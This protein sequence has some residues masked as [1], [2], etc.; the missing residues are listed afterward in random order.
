MAPHPRRLLLVDD[1]VRSLR[2]LGQLLSED[3]YEVSLASN[4]NEALEKLAKAPSLDGLITDLRMPGA[5]GGT[6]A[7]EA[8]RLHPKVPVLFVTQ[9]TELLGQLE[10]E[11][12]PPLHI[13]G[14]PVSY[15][16]LLQALGS[17][18][19]GD[20]AMDK[21]Q[22]IVVGDDQS[23]LGTRALDTALDMAHSHGNTNVHVL[24]AVELVVDPL[25]PYA[26]IPPISAKD[27]LGK[28]QERVMVRV[29]AA[30][31]RHQQLRVRSVIAHTAVGD[32]AHALVDL[33]AELDADQI[34]VGTHGRTGF[35]RA[36]LG[37][38][39]ERVVRHSGCPVTVVRAKAHDPEKR[40]PDIEP[41]CP[42]CK[43]EREK[44]GD[45]N[46]WC[47]RHRE[48]H[49]RAHVYHEGSDPPAS[50]RPWGFGG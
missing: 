13:L 26:G 21:A 6:V 33:A 46:T 28:E 41:L 10:R 48:H 8:R 45:V 22:I 20:R 16:E 35:S 30:L 12:G 11:L 31:G 18:T 5:D 7:R 40:V 2:M 19:V 17:P 49:P 4:G 23:D 43:K 36:I 24:Y 32:P 42:D 3:G 14:K 39:A 37:S 25:N 44:T 15:R 47:A 27:Q 1:D 9:Y 29:Q 38:I 50:V 34:V